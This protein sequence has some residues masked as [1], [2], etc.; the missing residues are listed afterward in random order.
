M[1]IEMLCPMGREPIGEMCE[2][3]CVFF[4]TQEYVI[5][6]FHNFRIRHRRIYKRLDHFKEILSQIQGKEGK[7]IQNEVVG[8]IRE[9]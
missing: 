2:E 3:C 9:T 7:E 5:T 8:R 4:E 6:D 1:C